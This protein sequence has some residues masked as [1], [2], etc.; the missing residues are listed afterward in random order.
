MRA[1]IAVPAMP[2]CALAV[3]EPVTQLQWK[4]EQHTD[5]WRRANHAGDLRAEDRELRGRMLERDP[6]VISPQFEI[7]ATPTE[8]IAPLRE[9]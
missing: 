3:A 5:G 4:S 2:A 8:F 1:A 6:F 7:P 9:P